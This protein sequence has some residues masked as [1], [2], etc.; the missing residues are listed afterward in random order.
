M[1]TAGAVFNMRSKQFD[2]VGE[3]ELCSGNVRGGK[4]SQ[5]LTEWKERH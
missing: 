5:L 3:M 1:R 4:A 2:N